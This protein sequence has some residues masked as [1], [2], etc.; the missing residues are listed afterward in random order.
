VAF[1]LIE[2]L[3]VIAII[4][5]LASLLLPA[6]SRAKGNAQSSKCQQNIRQLSLAW[7]L[8]AEDSEDRYVYNLGI[9]ETRSTRH[10]WVNN[11]L[12]WDNDADNTNTVLVTGGLLAPF[13]GGS[14]GL[15]KCPSDRSR[16][17]NGPRTRSISMNALVGNPGILTNRFNPLYRQFFKST[18]LVQPSQVFVLMDEHPDTLNDGFFMNRFERPDWG[19]LPGSYHSGSASMSFADG[20]QEMHRWQVTGPKGT[21][22]PPVQGG[23][24]GGF[25][26][27]PRTDYD[28]LIEHSSVKR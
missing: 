13:A 8:Y 14:A 6:L 12:S 20:H 1:T 18:D 7:T 24:D 3:V 26:A 15:F 2:L 23:A 17:V 10:N 5:I 9:D 21:V 19:N 25:P 11:V 27:E 28:W 22:R 4:G 16:A